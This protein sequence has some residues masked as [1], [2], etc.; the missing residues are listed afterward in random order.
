LAN[1]VA[2]LIEL[3]DLSAEDMDDGLDETVA[4]AGLDADGDQ[5]VTEEAADDRRL[6]LHRQ[7]ARIYQEELERPDD[8]IVCWA[9]VLTLA[10]HDEEAVD[11]LEELYIATESWSECVDILDRK[12]QNTPDPYDRV[13]I[14]ERMAEMSAEQLADPAG[15]RRAYAKILEV[16]PNNINAYE[17]LVTA[18]EENEQWEDLV[19]LLVGR[20][21]FAD[22]SYEQVELYSRTAEIFEKRLESKDNAFVVLSDAFTATLDDERFGIE[23]ARLAGEIDT[24]SPLIETYQKVINQ[25]GETMESVP[26]RLRVA[27]W[28]DE[29][30]ANVENAGIH[31]QNI[32]AIEPDNLEALSALELLLERNENWDNAVQV[33]ERK[34]ELTSDPDERKRAYEK[35]ANLLETKLDRGDD[36][37]DA[38][39]QAMLVDPSDLTLLDSLERLY[40]ARMRWEDLIGILDQQAV[41]LTDESLIV[42]KYLQIG[43][44]WETQM[45]SPDRAID[46]YRQALS[47]DDYNLDA[48]RALAKLYQQ[49]ENW[50]ETLDI[51]E[52]MLN[53]LEDADKKVEVYHRLA[54]LQREHMQDV[55][56]AVDTYR[57]VLGIRP[58][59]VTAVS[60]LESIFSDDARWPELVDIYELHLEAVTD[61]EYIQ[62]IRTLSAEI[63]RT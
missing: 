4:E 23:L 47:L 60:A 55:E 51:Y 38:Y 12:A 42:E 24:W 54:Q 6:E 16:Q 19:A 36:A 46:A 62:T 61:L 22:D 58:G 1:T 27:S 17:Q 33:L 11:H 29:K 52:L 39:R 44:L 31:Y 34:V 10:S 21:E 3:L 63:L 9:N 57:R 8:A 35:M 50:I 53:S 7:L 59:D 41:I 30:L 37:I 32:L 28:W 48:M 2:R 45:R 43:E 14:L 15:S 26:M 49:Q 56:G 18:Y 20:L 5:P 13:S 40:M 25:V